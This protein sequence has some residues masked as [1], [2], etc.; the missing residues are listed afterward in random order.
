MNINP[1]VRCA[2][3]LTTRNKYSNKL[4]NINIKI[5]VINNQTLRPE[6]YFI[7]SHGIGQSQNQSRRNNINTDISNN[8]SNSIYRSIGPTR[9][10]GCVHGIHDNTIS[11]SHLL[12][13]GYNYN[14]E[15]GLVHNERLLGGVR[16]LRLF[17]RSI[18]GNVLR[19]TEALF[20]GIASYV[21]VLMD[22]SGLAPFIIIM[23]LNLAYKMYNYRKFF[24]VTVNAIQT[25][26]DRIQLVT[27]APL[28]LPRI[29]DCEFDKAKITNASG[30]TE[31]FFTCT[32]TINDYTPGGPGAATVQV[33]GYKS[34][35]NLVG[36]NST[37]KPFKKDLVITNINVISAGRVVPIYEVPPTLI[38][39][40]TASNKTGTTANK[41]DPK[42]IKEAE[43]VSEK[44]YR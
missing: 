10:M 24:D 5:N 37:R 36:T 16:Y 8:S 20:Y 29:Q 12:T 13:N 35:F 15:L 2:L 1:I 43:I 7:S 22:D 4:N 26:R 41:L 34:P 31:K 23:L 18:I 44:K 11:R 17:S 6:Y 27:K 21:L 3:L 33:L 32:F 9:L 38:M 40:S 28:Q 25:H 30:A 42:L 14:I 19:S 39:D